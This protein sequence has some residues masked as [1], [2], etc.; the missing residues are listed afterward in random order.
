MLLQKSYSKQK[1]CSQNLTAGPQTYW[2]PR[3]MGLT[4][5]VPLP[6]TNPPT[7]Q[8]A[9]ILVNVSKIIL[10]NNYF[11]LQIFWPNI[12]LGS[13]FFLDLKCNFVMECQGGVLNVFGNCPKLFWILC[14]RFTTGPP[15]GRV[16]AMIAL[17]HETS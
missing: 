5:F 16:A 13:K 3:A 4:Q 6:A 14:A 2:T 12:F 17:Q 10:S 8:P 1:A 9:I 7:Y 11:G 15:S